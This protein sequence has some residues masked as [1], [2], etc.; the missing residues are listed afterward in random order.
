MKPGIKWIGFGLAI[1]VIVFIVWAISIARIFSEK[2]NISVG[3]DTVSTASSTDTVH[4]SYFSEQPLPEPVVFA[5]GVIST[6]DDEAHATFTPTGET[7]YF[8]KN[9]PNFAHWTVVTSEFKNGHWSTPEVAPFSGRYSDA[10]VSFSQDGNTLFFISNRPVKEGGEPKEDTDI[11]RIRKTKDG[12]SKPEHIAAL[13]SPLNEW[14]PT[15][16]NDGTIYFGSERREDNRGTAGTSDLWRS[17]WVNGHYTAPE[18]L[19]DGINTTGQDIEAYIAPDERFMIFSS[20]GREDTHGSYDLYISYNQ[21]GTWSEPQNL[22]D[23]INSNGWEFGA[24]LSP[25]GRYLFFTSNRNF[26]D[27]P[28]EYRLNYQKLIKKIR[29]PGNGLRDIY[30]VDADVLPPPSK[31]H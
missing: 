25:D 24:K 22:G 18:N 12:W 1:L 10:D 15:V 4:P 13:S 7:L 30:Q 28:T 17:E 19:G 6:G 5:P 27:F 20:N 8:I 14:F 29:S 2:S 9:T 23:S 3:Q 16:S 21:N 31:K 26:Y 11:W